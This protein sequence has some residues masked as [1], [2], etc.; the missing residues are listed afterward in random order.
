MSGRKFWIY[1]TGRTVSSLSWA[2]HLKS[3]PEQ[4]GRR[5]G[6]QHGSVSFKRYCR[7]AKRLLAAAIRTRLSV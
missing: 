1:S 6:L 4:H 2:W 7:Q 3:A 5:L